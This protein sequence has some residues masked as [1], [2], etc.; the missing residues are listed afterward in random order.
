MACSCTGAQC[1]CFIDG[2]TNTTITGS[3]TAL[4]PFLVH[5]SIPEVTVADTPSLDLTKAGE[6]VTGKVRLDPLFGVDDT[7]TVELTL[8]GAGTEASPF[9]LT[10]D[11]T[12]IDLSGA[13]IGDVVTRLIDGTWGPGPATQAEVGSVSTSNGVTGDGSGGSPVRIAAK[14]Y[15][16]W[17]AIIDASP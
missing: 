6:V 13:A 3:G 1:S 7:A 2:G 10:A 8:T 4:D 15:A 12:D 14:T 5:C 9:T 11:L 16:Q 17:E